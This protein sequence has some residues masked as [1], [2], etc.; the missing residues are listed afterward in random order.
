MKILFLSHYFPPEGNAPASRVYEMAK[1][2]VADGH[3]VD[4]ITCAPNVPNGVVYEG[5]KNRLRQTEMID[6]IRV[7]R[8][9]TVLAANKGTTMRILNYLSYMV[10]ALFSGLFVRKPDLV[11]ATSPQFFCGWAGVM[12]SRLRRL[13]FI[14]EIR[15]IWPESIVA[16]GALQNQRLLHFLER[17]KLK[18][19]KAADHIV[20]VGQG[21]AD[22]LVE[23]G[24]PADKISIVMN[25]VDEEIFSPRPADQELAVRLGV[26]GRFVCSYI[27]TIGMACGLGVVLRAAKMLKDE[28]RKDICFAIVGDGAVRQELEAEAKQAQLDNVVF[29]G[30]LD[31]SDIPKVL[32][33]TDACLVHLKKTDL[34]KT[35][36][37]S[38]IFEA[39]GMAKP[40][41]I[42]VWGFAE[43]V[44]MDAQA[45]LPM[46]PENDEELVDAVL[47]LADDPELSKTLGQSGHKY[48]MERYN[49]DDLASK[50][51][52]IIE[53]TLIA[54]AN[55]DYTTQDN[56]LKESI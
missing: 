29:T 32:S 47:K 54:S 44:V 48:I 3:K 46:E 21:Y 14:L 28:G 9:W 53:D 37:P 18:M 5:Y 45:G 26:K 13:P 35:V 6:G 56:P 4:V 20:T 8:I 1:R 22:R 51:I 12:L 41:I 23:Q 50:Y 30:R 7:I 52:G 49:R 38:K 31:K 55:P 42:G 2:W 25:G 34:F 11:I 17:L 40:I 39:A 33:I 24:V 15:D 19:Y 36:M 10:S 27:G 16:V 43:Q